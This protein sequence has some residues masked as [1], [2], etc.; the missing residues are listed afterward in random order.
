MSNAFSISLPAMAAQA[1]RSEEL[2][3]RIDRR[4]WSHAAELCRDGDWLTL[5]GEEALMLAAYLPD[6]LR[7]DHGEGTDWHVVRE[8]VCSW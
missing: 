2:H 4:D 6:S 8:G 5:T 3:W 1:D 7:L